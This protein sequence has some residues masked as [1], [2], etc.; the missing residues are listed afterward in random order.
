MLQSVPDWRAPPLPDRTSHNH[1]WHS[2]ETEYL[3]RHILFDG[4]RTLVLPS[5][6]PEAEAAADFALCIVS[7]GSFGLDCRLSDN[8]SGFYDKQAVHVVVS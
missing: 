5:L 1:L 6:A 7:T 2:Y 3:A 8:A 4:A